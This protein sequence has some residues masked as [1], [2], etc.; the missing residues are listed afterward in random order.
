MALLEL[1]PDPRI[2]IAI[3][4]RD[5]VFGDADGVLVGSME[6]FEA[7]VNTTEAVSDIEDRLNK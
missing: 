4:R 5:A 1:S 6:T 7:L 2:A 3:L